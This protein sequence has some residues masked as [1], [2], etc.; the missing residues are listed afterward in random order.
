MLLLH[1]ILSDCFTNKTN[2]S[3]LLWCFTRLNINASLRP[4]SR[5][6]VLIINSIKIIR[7]IG[8]S[9]L[10]GTVS[11]SIRCF[12]QTTCI[13]P[14]PPP[15]LKFKGELK[16]D[17]K[18]KDKHTYPSPLS[19]TSQKLFTLLSNHAAHL[20]FQYRP[21]CAEWTQQSAPSNE[22]IHSCSSSWK[23]APLGDGGSLIEMLLNV[24]RAI[25]AGREAFGETR[26][27]KTMVPCVC[28][29]FNMDVGS[30]SSPL[31]CEIFPFCVLF[32]RNWRRNVAFKRM[33]LE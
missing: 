25:N 1:N 12:L 20:S 8:V 22:N 24:H 32:R 17:A 19:T 16:E 7:S 10:S 26:G 29:W 2:I 33:T 30:G 28:Q 9:T 14:T 23:E 31:K 15:P 4:A 11:I 27:S 13:L 5:N 21:E 6:Q 18:M 3:L